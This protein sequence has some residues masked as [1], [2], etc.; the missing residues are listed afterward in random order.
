MFSISVAELRQNPAP[1]LDA[2]ARG[3][4]LTVTRY[5]R[6]VARLVPTARPPVRGADVMG[7][8]ASTPV[9]S[10]WAQ[11]LEAERSTDRAVDPWEH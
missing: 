6:P 5:R 4:A 11:Q 1:A 2:V 9:D 10:Q 3:Q 8:L 7:V